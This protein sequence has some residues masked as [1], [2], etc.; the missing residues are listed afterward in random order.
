MKPGPV[1]CGKVGLNNE[2]PQNSRIK[3]RLSHNNKATIGAELWSDV[4]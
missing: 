1:Q 3:G 4:F 2:M